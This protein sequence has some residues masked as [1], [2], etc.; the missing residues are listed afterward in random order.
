MDATRQILEAPLGATKTPTDSLVQGDHRRQRLYCTHFDHRS[1][2]PDPIVCTPSYL[3]DLDCL[4]STDQAFQGDAGLSFTEFHDFGLWPMDFPTATVLG[5]DAESRLGRNPEECLTPG[6][7]AF[8]DVQHVQSVPNEP[9][10][11]MTDYATQ[12]IAHWF[13]EVCPAWSGFDSIKNM[14]RKLAEDL[15]HSSS[16]VFNSLQS[17]S[18]SFLA[19]RLPQMRP[20]A[21]RLLKTATLCIQAE[22]EELKGKA[23][24]DTAP[25]GVIYSLLCLGTTIC[26]LDARRVGWPFLQDAKSLLG[27]TMQQDCHLS[28]GD[29]NILDFFSKSLVY[30]EMLIS[31]IYDPEP[32]L[33]QPNLVGASNFDSIPHPWTGISS[34]T[35]RLFTLS[36][37]VCRTYRSRNSLS[38]IGGTGLP[39]AREVGEAEELEKHL[40]QLQLSPSPLIEDTGDHRTPYFHLLHVA[41]AYQLASLLQLYITFPDLVSS[42]VPLEH[43]HSYEGNVMWYK[44]IVPLALRLTEVLE[45]V[46]PDSGSLVI[47]PLL[48]VCAATGLRCDTVPKPGNYQDGVK[49]SG[50]PSRPMEC[51]LDYVSLLDR[52][53]ENHEREDY[54]VTQ[55]A[56][57][58]SQARNFIMRRISVLKDNLHP[59]PVRVTEKLVKAVW[60][61]YDEEPQGGVSVHWLDVMEQKDLRTLFG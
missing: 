25:I 58:V 55:L 53:A 46:P 6:L 14:N 13:H 5:P 22:V 37:S 27:R 7:G 33:A 35:S 39:P 24:L 60:T 2:T 18:A 43:H 31:F 45:R 9:L 32:G 56:L 44:W 61:A 1:S 21:F 30:W 10:G 3:M 49:E 15:W 36:M 40:L 20:T 42:R 23:H 34:F 50:R 38:S 8:L 54:L 48:Y 47:Q 57:N 12:L 29:A 16:A 41:E 17:M 26:W 52:P 59:V 51:I 4:E 28:E 19:A 11:R